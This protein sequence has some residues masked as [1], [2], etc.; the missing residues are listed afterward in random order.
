[1][2]GDSKM[3]EEIGVTADTKDPDGGKIQRLPGSNKPSGVLEELAMILVVN[4]MPMPTPE[5]AMTMLDEGMRFYA[6]AGITTAQDC[7]S[8]KGAIKI[9]EAMERQGKLPIDIIT[10]PL[11][12]GVDDAEFKS[13]IKDK[14]ST[15]RLRRGGLKMTV[16]GSIQGY[17]AFLSQPYH[18]QPGQT[19][20]TADKCVTDTVEHLF[21]SSDT[22]SHKASEPEKVEGDY[23]GY[24]NMT[25]E[26]IETWLKRCDDAGIQIQA[27]TNGDGA[28]DMLVKAVKSVRGGR[29]LGRT[30]VQPS[31]TLRPCVRIN[32]ISQQNK[33]L[34]CH[35]FQSMSIFGETDIETCFSA[36]NVHPGLALHAQLWTGK[37]KLP[38]TTMHQLLVLRCSLSPGLRSTE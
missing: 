10:W 6:R 8:G 1:M 27:H 25:Q 5:K 15:G 28:T 21:I 2:A 29:S 26:E 12:Q 30:F 11:Y 19:A 4:K 9:L 13:V 35:S 7:A 22:E 17:T 3:L 33:A 37:L 24:S 36:R 38:C 14:D 31:S 34:L 16:D 23:R 32:S 18:V 20:P